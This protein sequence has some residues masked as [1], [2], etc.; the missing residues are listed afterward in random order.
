MSYL[1]PLLPTP[2]AIGSERMLDGMFVYDTDSLNLE[3]GRSPA[4]RMLLTSPAGVPEPSESLKLA[5]DRRQRR[6]LRIKTK[7]GQGRPLATATERVIAEE[8]G[9]GGEG[10]VF[11][12]LIHRLLEMVDWEKPEG[13]EG[14]IQSEARALG[15][16]SR[17]AV[18]ADQMVR[19][20]LASDLLK[21]IRKSDRYFK[22]VPF[23]WKDQGTIV[24]G[25]ID[26]VF[27]EGADL[28]V[29]DFK[30]DMVSKRHLEAKVRSYKPQTDV[31][32]HAI[33]A[34]WGRLPKDVIL[35]FLQHLRPVS[36]K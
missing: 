18:K 15:V 13:L 9:D 29:V 3:P 33:E 36:V 23:A 22:E 2:Q 20:A 25:K 4:F 35:F 5:L 17:M 14:M 32:A 28:V 31:Y 24:E 12:T 34:T 21:R 11:G 16:P 6:N 8:A 1:A 7:A 19:A 30:T 27:Q 10:V 26:V